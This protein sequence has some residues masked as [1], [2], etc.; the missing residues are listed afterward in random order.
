MQILGIYLN[1]GDPKVIKNLKTEDN[2]GPDKCWY[3]FGKIPD[4][5]TFFTKTFDE[6]TYTNFLKNIKD[7]QDFNHFLYKIDNGPAVN[8]NCIVGKNGSGKSSLLSLE[9]RIIN[10]LACKVQ[11]YLKSYNQDFTP[12]WSTGF[13]AELYY[14]IDTSLFQIKVTENQDFEIINNTD[15][16]KYIEKISLKVIE[17]TNKNVS[18]TIQDNEYITREIKFD[19]EDESVILKTIAEKI[20]YTVG[21]N[22][23]IYSNSQVTDKW[24]IEEEK[25]MNTIFHKNDGY[26]TP[27]VLVPYKY[28]NCATVDTRKEL[29]LAK[30]RITTLALLVYAET[31]NNFVENQQPIKYCYQLKWKKTYKKEIK[32]KL[33]NII[34]NTENE[35]DDVSYQKL[36]NSAFINFLQKQIKEKWIAILFTPEKISKYKNALIN[37]PDRDVIWDQ[38][39]ENTLNY[40]AYKILKMCLFYDEYANRFLDQSD[41]TSTEPKLK[42]KVLSKYKSDSTS[43]MNKIEA[44]IQEL[45]DPKT[46][47]NFM[48]LKIKQCIEFL[49]NLDFYIGNKMIKE[50]LNNKNIIVID[51][52]KTDS[53][54]F[55]NFIKNK[56]LSYSYDNVFIN[57]LPPFFNKELI[58]ENEKTLSSLSSGESQLMNSLSYAVYHIK[59]ASSSNKIGYQYINLVFDEAELYYHP[60]F[61]RT[62]IQKL[63]GVIERSNFS[64]VKS[65]NITI[66]TH[67]P[68]IL[69]DIPQTNLLSL[70][71]GTK[72]DFAAKTLGA[73]FYDLLHNQ[74]F[75]D[76]SIGAV[77]EKII[78][79]IINDFNNFSNPEATEEIKENIR[80]NYLPLS[81]SN[82]ISNESNGTTENP[83]ITFVNNLADDYLK[84]TFQNMIATILGDDFIERRKRELEEKIK[85][86]D[87]LKREQ[88]NE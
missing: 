85:E 23:S 26:F 6:N 33:L 15:T 18:K 68:F 66:V 31:N 42:Y 13:N 29:N 71:E 46:A 75:M 12:V 55:I 10:N 62:F 32:N 81:I 25:W 69:S 56:N 64:K 80:Q 50:I 37:N 11:H 47:T 19:S 63:L 51:D 40:L 73:N 35:E 88:N 86:L 22:Y 20:F 5:H 34:R 77:A 53:N 59:N 36:S 3:P 52:S 60:E 38:I 83:Y 21:T 30:E 8:I 28:D 41:Y 67:S 61:Q 14:L 49:S 45:L 16:P 2:H 1:S 17:P 79:T 48:N 24:D 65:I 44:L 82:I 70:T 27:I 43:F 54:T 39:Q 9:Y 4:C 87:N 57:L 84:T 58:Y 76:S 7:N 72:K 78:N 74:F